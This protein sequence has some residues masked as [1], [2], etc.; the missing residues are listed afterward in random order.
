MSRPGGAR[1]VEVEVENHEGPSCPFCPFCQI[2]D[3]GSIP[4]DPRQMRSYE[5]IRPPLVEVCQGLAQHRA[6][7]R[8]HHPADPVLIEV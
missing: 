3:V 8:G 1:C 4:P 6:L 2:E 5:H 7:I